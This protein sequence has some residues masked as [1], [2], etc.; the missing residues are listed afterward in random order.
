MWNWGPTQAPP[1]IQ[2]D[3]AHSNRTIGHNCQV[4]VQPEATKG[5]ALCIDAR[6]SRWRINTIPYNTRKPNEEKI[7]DNTHNTQKYKNNI[8]DVLSNHTHQ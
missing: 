8:H 7:S 2:G 3:S 4:P 1:H 6:L 5:H